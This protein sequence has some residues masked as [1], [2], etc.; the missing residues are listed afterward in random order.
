MSISYTTLVEA[1]AGIRFVR[2]HNR[3]FGTSYCLI[4]KE[5]P[6]K[7]PDFGV[8]D[9]R[10]GVQIGMEVKRYETV[11]GDIALDQKAGKEYLETGKIVPTPIPGTNGLRGDITLA[12]TAIKL[13]LE[14]EIS[15]GVDYEG[16]TGIL[17]VTPFFENFW[18]CHELIT[19]HG[20]ILPKL[21]DGMRSTFP[22]GVWL[23]ARS[24]DKEERDVLDI[25]C[26]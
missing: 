17:L 25:T 12:A 10:L 7:F 22:G 4:E 26:V 16:H 21:V 14:K 23:F 8:A 3:R 19:F 5:S 13:V 20:G 6:Y 9:K 24:E 18:T 1:L 11:L 2:A 15:E